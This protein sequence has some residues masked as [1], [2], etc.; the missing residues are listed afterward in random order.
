MNSAI[1]Y[2]MYLLKA[3]YDKNTMTISP[4]E[5][6]P[7]MTSISNEISIFITKNDTDDANLILGM[8]S[9]VYALLNYI[10]LT[11]YPFEAKD[12]ES[13]NAIMSKLNLC[14][15]KRSEYRAVITYIF[16]SYIRINFFIEN[17]YANV[18][19][20]EVL[21]QDDSTENSNDIIKSILSKFNESTPQIEYQS[22]LMLLIEL[23]AKYKEKS[24][25]MI[26]NQKIF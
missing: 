21:N 8:I 22:F 16:I 9:L 12:I 23:V 25:D 26:Q 14:Y 19:L 1:D 6:I 7:L 5:L 24:F 17:N 10:I 18:M 2:A 11:K 15:I 3:N 20:N 4:T 13:L